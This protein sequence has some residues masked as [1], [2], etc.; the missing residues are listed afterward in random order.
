MDTDND[1][2]SADRKLGDEWK[3]WDGHSTEAESRARKRLFFSLTGAYLLALLGLGLFAWYLIAPRLAQW[4]ALAPT[5]VLAAW[6]LIFV[7]QFCALGLVALT[8]LAHLPMP[9]W[10]SS[11]VRRLLV[12]LEGGVFSLGAVLSLNRDRIAHSFVLVHNAL[13]RINGHRIEPGRILVLLPRCL[14]REQ[15]RQANSMASEYGVSVAVVAG[16]ELARQR[17][18]ERRPQ[19]VIGV[20]CERDLMSGIRDVRGRLC[21]LG[22]PNTRPHGPCKD[23]HIELDEL[24]RAVDFYISPPAPARSHSAPTAES[25]ACSSRS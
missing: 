10:L 22:I 13:V 20:A 1:R 16:G 21:V 4:H 17:I 5:A 11:L 14:T 23:T 6:L 7:V 2:E 3:D 9:R 18:R 24:R 19:A 25:T 8:L 12:H 15:I